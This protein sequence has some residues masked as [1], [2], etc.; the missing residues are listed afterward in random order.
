MMQ[1]IKITEQDKDILAEMA[2]IGT[3]NA[4][5]ALSHMLNHEKITLEVPEVRIAPLQNV[6]E[7]VGDPEQ[8]VAVI[9]MEAVS[10]K[11]SLTILLVLSF[12]A[13]MSLIS[14]LLPEGYEPL[15]EMGRSLLVELGNILTGSYLGALAAMTGLTFTLAPPVLGLDMAGAL[16]GSVI[17]EKMMLD[18]DFILI[19]T[20]MH[21]LDENVDG[22]ILLLPTAGS[23]HTT[24]QQ[25][26]D[27]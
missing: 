3:G 19:K 2:N 15:G 16:L 24:F 13:I 18:D 27:C 11:L 1:K 26:G 20:T 4:A 12:P 9:M 23:L 10:S 22:N 17:A 6:P 14:R 7:S 5:T 21:I 25:L 8:K